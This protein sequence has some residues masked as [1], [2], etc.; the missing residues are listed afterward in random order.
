[1]YSDMNFLYKQKK[2]WYLKEPFLIKLALVA[3][4]FVLFIVF[5]FYM[6]LAEKNHQA[7]LLEKIKTEKRELHNAEIK[8]NEVRSLISD[9]EFRWNNIQNIMKGIPEAWKEILDNMEEWLE[10][11]LIITGYT[12]DGEG[13]SLTGNCDSDEKVAELAFELENSGIYTD[14]SIKSINYSDNYVTFHMSGK[15]IWGAEKHE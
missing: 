8:N 4:I 10:G 7:F 14:M 6:P 1:M 15:I 9:C 2:R 3:A 12:C 5:G 13:V 11:P